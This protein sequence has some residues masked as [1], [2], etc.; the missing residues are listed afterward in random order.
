MWWCVSGR[1]TTSYIF[2]SLLLLKYLIA[3]YPLLAVGGTEP[4]GSTSAAQVCGALHIFD[5]DGQIIP[6]VRRTK[7]KEPKNQQ[8]PIQCSALW[9]L[10]GQQTF[11]SSCFHQHRLTFHLKPTVEYCSPLHNR[12]SLNALPPKFEGLNSTQF[13]TGAASMAPCSPISGNCVGKWRAP[14]LES[15]LVPAV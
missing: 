4:A 2:F 9:I 10:V 6:E 7:Q 3:K 5:H 15:R 1:L 12:S 14:L 11:L 8:T 13:T